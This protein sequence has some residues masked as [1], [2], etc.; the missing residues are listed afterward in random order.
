MSEAVCTLTVAEIEICRD[1]LWRRGPISA[2]NIDALCD[3]AALAVKLE[4]ILETLGM[5]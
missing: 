5:E 1:L 4:Y 2:S 3:Q